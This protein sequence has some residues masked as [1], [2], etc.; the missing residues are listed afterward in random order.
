MPSASDLSS[1]QETQRRGKRSSDEAAGPAGRL[2]RALDAAG[3]KRQRADRGGGPRPPDQLVGHRRRGLADRHL[4][5]AHR[6]RRGD[7]QLLRPAIH[8]GRRQ[9]QGH[10]HWTVLDD[11][12]TSGSLSYVVSGLRKAPGTTCRCGPSTATGMGAG[13]TPSPRRPPTTAT[14]AARRRQ[15][16]W[17]TTYPERSIPST[18]WTTSPLPSP[19]RPMSGCTPLAIPILTATSTTRTGRR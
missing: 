10:S 19:P 17:A 2:R 1:C 8:R 13:R 18:T 5:R 3:D 9:R 6:R 16:P 4:E 7:D 12:W 15:Q 14:R 11:V